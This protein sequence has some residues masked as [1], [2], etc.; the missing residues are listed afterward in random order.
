MT[1]LFKPWEIL[2]HEWELSLFT[3]SNLISTPHLPCRYLVVTSNTVPIFGVPSN[4]TF[5]VSWF[6]VSWQSVLTTCHSFCRLQ[7]LVSVFCHEVLSGFNC[8]QESCIITNLYQSILLWEPFHS[9]LVLLKKILCME[10]S[11]K[12]RCCYQQSCWLEQWVSLSCQNKSPGSC[13]TGPVFITQI[14]DCSVD[15]ELIN[16]NNCAKNSFNRI[17]IGTEVYWSF[18]TSFAFE[19]SLGQWTRGSDNWVSAFSEFDHHQFSDS[20]PFSLWSFNVSRI[21]LLFWSRSEEWP[22]SWWKSSRINRSELGF[23]FAFLLTFFGSP[24]D[25]IEH[26]HEDDSSFE[27]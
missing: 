5:R 17:T 18:S 26:R 12:H 8:F 19:R 13:L 1:N 23:R 9:F 3:D 15:T 25:V 20:V 24:W 2:T 11:R 16:R 10:F 7:E 6:F 14:W 27:L 22:S 21:H 4:P